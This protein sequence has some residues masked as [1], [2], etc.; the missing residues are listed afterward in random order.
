MNLDYE[1]P[2]KIAD[3]IYWIGYYDKETGLHCNPYLII[4]N[5]EAVI[6]DGGSRLSFPTVLEK[7]LQ[8]GVSLLSI[9]ALIY[10]HYDP[11]LYGSIR[12]F[13]EAIDK[14]NLLVIS[15][16]EYTHSGNHCHNKSRHVT[17]L[18]VQCK[19]EFSSGRRLQFFK[20]PYS[21]LEGSFVTF[22]QQSGVLFTSDLFGSYSRKWELFLNLESHCYTCKDLTDC[23]G[24]K[25]HCPIHCILDFHKRI[26][27]SNKALVLALEQIVKI[28]CSII[29]PQHGSVI[30][31]KE[32]IQHIYSLLSSIG[33]VGIDSEG[34]EQL[35]KKIIRDYAAAEKKLAEL[36]QIK[37]RFL[38]MTAHDLRNPIASIRGFSELFLTESFGV[39]TAEQ[40]EYMQ[41]IYTTSDQMLS[42]V[43]DLLD[44]AVIESGK[45]DLKRQK[46][47]L[48]STVHERVRIIRPIAQKK[49]IAIHEQFADY[50]EIY[51]DPQ[52]IAQV[53]DN[54]VGNAIK[55]SPPNKEIYISS[56]QQDNMIGICVK[57][58]GPGLSQNDKTKLCG[59]F[60]TLSAR[61]TGG[62]KSTGLGLAIVKKIIEAH[63]GMLQVEGNP[64]GGAVFS[65][66]IPMRKDA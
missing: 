15:E 59:D 40:K 60:Q 1:Q 47:S 9:T 14:S 61:P 4:D 52:R 50:G 48:T 51:F 10:Q 63:G 3:G 2:I 18:D 28:P 30:H 22:D 49:S 39:L 41:M 36:N 33:N 58:E 55:F 8:T 42:M 53:V 11:D 25:N 21:Y 16:K 6:I 32:D 66:L 62:E 17:L 44:V 54:L 65:F 27:M 7:I 29:A 24:A 45:L 20:T 26:M 23:I 38:G 5:D 64:G 13:E 12:I 34:D 43:N 56:V 57:D 35:L 37:N 46:G 31:K 19:L